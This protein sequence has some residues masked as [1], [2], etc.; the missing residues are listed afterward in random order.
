MVFVGGLG[1]GEMWIEQFAS[2]LPTV[3]GWAHTALSLFFFF[4]FFTCPHLRHPCRAISAGLYSAR[5]SLTFDIFKA[6]CWYV[7]TL[8]ALQ[9]FL[10]SMHMTRVELLNTALS[11]GFNT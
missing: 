8:I 7:A 3:I 10:S 6:V 4:I 2:H 1:E 9:W 11:D 5:G